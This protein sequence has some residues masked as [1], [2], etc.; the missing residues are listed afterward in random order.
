MAKKEALIIL[1]DTVVFTVAFSVVGIVFNAVREKG[2]PLIAT[3][4]YE[5]Y[6]PCPEPLGEVWPMAPDAAEVRDSRTILIDARSAEE[7]RDWHAPGAIHVLYDYLD[8][9][10]DEVLDRL[11]GE[12][13]RSGKARVV[14]Y[15]DGE[16]KMGDTGYE[17]GRE[18]SGR[19]LRN[20][21][22]IEADVETFKRS[23]QP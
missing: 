20:V 17:L 6:V 5:I 21:Y 16:G 14:V 13:A 18:L 23:L 7:Y 3:E 8:P 15:G 10:P 2:I 1:R 22:V 11:S 12:F 9:L 19:G 4:A